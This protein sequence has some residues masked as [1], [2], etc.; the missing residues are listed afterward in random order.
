MET[1]STGM[2]TVAK[3]R[4]IDFTDG[5]ILKNILVFIWPLLVHQFLQTTYNSVGMMIVGQ[6]S[7]NGSLA[8]GAISAASTMLSFL[9]SIFSGISAGTGICVALKIGA[10][11]EK[12]VER[13][14]HS[15]AVF[16]FIGG[17][18]LMIIGIATIKPFLILTEVPESMMAEATAYMVAY[19]LGFP[20]MMVLNSMSASLRASGDTYHT[21]IFMS[22][23]GAVNLLAT[24]ILVFGFG[25]G[26]VAAG[27][28]VTVTQ[29][30]AVSL[31][32]GYMM[33]HDGMLRFSFKKLALFK[34]AVKGFLYCGVPIGLQSSVF[35]LANIF[36][37]G[38]INIYGD[39][40]IA[41]S[42]AA[43]SLTNYIHSITNAL[44]VALL[45]IVSQNMGAKRYDR[46]KRTVIVMT[47]AVVI[48]GLVM[49]LAI[50]IFGEQLL[51]LYVS[52]DDGLDYDAVIYEGMVRA[53]TYTLPYFLYGV[54]EC[55]SNTLNGMKKSV[56][57]M[58]LSLIGLCGVRIVWVIAANVMFPQSVALI[59]LSSP[60]SCLATALMETVAIVV[61]FKR[62]SG[63]KSRE[64]GAL[65]ENL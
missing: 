48:I 22:V 17:A 63:E 56:I 37:Q 25:L 54:V 49:G 35:S 59:H 39:V 47:L 31:I 62:L 9:M 28:G 46:V 5:P 34:D 20:A 21:M 23:A 64:N 41:G 30:V 43:N 8:M 65:L 11:D 7:P 55:F 4:V 1:R 27:V 40:V 6:Y 2:S 13:Y 61:A 26:A 10:R 12:E 52:K 45:T 58:T 51:G 32:L 19:Y 57:S 42:A 38:Y 44:A 60:V 3:K 29:I 33:R 24:A 16:S 50:Y 18:V 36:I 53:L 14:I 15:S